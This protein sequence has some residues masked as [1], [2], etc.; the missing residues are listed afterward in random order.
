MK[1]YWWATMVL[2]V[3]LA[4]GCNTPCQTY[5]QTLTDHFAAC[6]SNGATTSQDEVWAWEQLGAGSAD[7]YYSR[8]MTHWDGALSI[9][10]AEDRNEI[11]DW[12]TT[13]DIWVAGQQ[14]CD[15]NLDLPGY[16]DFIN[17]EDTEE[18]VP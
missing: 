9:A 4:T 1:T 6:V 7:D 3:V 2:L 5:C 17:E 12:C 13:A 16:P 14:D 10:L 18:T 15:A 8:C 11:Y